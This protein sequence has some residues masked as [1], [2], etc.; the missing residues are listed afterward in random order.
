[1]DTITPLSA[2]G[3]ATDPAAPMEFISIEE[4]AARLHIDPASV[5]KRLQRGKL[6]GQKDDNTWMGVWWTATVAATVREETAPDAPTLSETDAAVRV[7]QRQ[8]ADLERDRDRA[9]QQ[10]DD[11]RAV[12]DSLLDIMRRQQETTAT[13][14]ATVRDRYETD[15]ARA[16]EETAQVRALLPPSPPPRRGWFARLFGKAAPDAR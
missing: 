11:L 6:T 7:L 8:V 5:R 4:A 3:P 1:M 2:D 13:A 12:R 15:L 14:L 16:A 10:V 9:Y